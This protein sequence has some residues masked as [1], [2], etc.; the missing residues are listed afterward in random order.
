[1][2]GLSESKISAKLK[3]SKTAVHQSI[4]KFEQYG[5]Y[6]DLPRSGRPRKNTVTEDHV[7]KRIVTRSQMSSISKIRGALV[8]RGVSVSRMTVSRRLSQEFIPK[9][10]KPARKPRLTPAIKA[11]RLAFAKKHPNWMTKEWGKVMFS[12]ESTMQQFV[13]RKRHVRRP[14]GTRVYAEIHNFYDETS[15]K[16]DDLGCNFW[17]W[18]NW[19]LLFAA[20][21][22]YERPSLCWIA[23]GKAENSYGRA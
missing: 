4:K 12:D 18:C 8:E 3:V 16:S 19:A 15:N 11:K 22:D 23:G 2:K 17:K 10:R 14:R 7:M 5:S 21:I 1:M 20:W 13:V 6:K 9:S